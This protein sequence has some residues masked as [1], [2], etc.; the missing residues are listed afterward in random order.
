[1]HKLRKITFSFHKRFQRPPE[2]LSGQIGKGIP[3]K[4]GRGGCF[5][6]VQILTQSFEKKKQ[7]NMYQRKEYKKSPEID[8]KEMK[9]Y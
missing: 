6:N 9:I 5:A 7:G 4:T 2:S 8:S 3:L 1:M